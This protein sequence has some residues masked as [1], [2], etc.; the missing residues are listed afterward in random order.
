MCF[1]KYLSDEYRTFFVI[2]L[3]DFKV[4]L[5][6]LIIMSSNYLLACRLSKTPKKRKPIVFKLGMNLLTISFEEEQM[7]SNSR[8][9]NN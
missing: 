8:R 5:I 9:F 1:L 3:A 2:N 6:K 4:S 7:S